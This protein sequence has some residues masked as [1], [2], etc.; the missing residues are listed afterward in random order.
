MQSEVCLPVPSM[1]IDDNRCARCGQC[2]AVCIRGCLMLEKD[3]LIFTREDR[4]IACGHCLAVCPQEGT[5]NHS[6]LP[7]G[8]FIPLESASL[9]D[10]GQLVRLLRGRRSVRHYRPDPVPKETVRE[11]LDLASFAPTARN[12]QEVRLI[13]V[14][15]PEQ[16]AALSGATLQYY[17]RLVRLLGSPAVTAA[18]K[19][20]LGKEKAAQAVAG[21]SSLD[22]LLERHGRGMDPIFFRAPLLIIPYGPKNDPF[23]KDDS[24]YALYN[25][26][27]G[28]ELAGL[29]SCLIG[30]FVLAAKR[31]K[32]IH[33]AL[34][35]GPREAVHAACVFGYPQ[36]TF[37]RAVPRRPVHW[38]GL[39]QA[40]K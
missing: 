34:G 37:H 21:K 16:V 19:M 12:R 31:S 26:I 14:D 1:Q 25:M 27:L 10:P 6:S 4:C 30:Y 24:L 29:G 38:R 22:A 40:E 35:L 18:A 33:Q 36:F 11:L 5:L 17:R 20:P 13:V 39:P 15:H 32:D 8:G 3:G 7:G 28:A 2:A 9:P 23:H